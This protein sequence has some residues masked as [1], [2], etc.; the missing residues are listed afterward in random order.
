MIILG[1]ETSCD[2]TAVS[3]VEAKGELSS[4]DFK[5]LCS[6][7]H[8][9]VDIHKEYGGV[10]PTLAKRVHIK[11]MPLVLEQALKQA[12]FSA[13]GENPGID[14]IAVTVGPGLEPALWVGIKRSEERRVGEE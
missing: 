2:E 4:L 9:Q 1:I 13:N 8:S 6:A 11:N 10:F 7:V 5:V 12:N 14:M 3:V